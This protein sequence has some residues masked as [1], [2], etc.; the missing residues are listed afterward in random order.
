VPSAELLRPLR[1]STT[2]TLRFVTFRY[3]GA[4]VVTFFFYCESGIL[5]A[6][7]HSILRHSLSG[8]GDR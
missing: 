6:S 4:D 7:R 1:F 3:V 8:F 5:T 2:V